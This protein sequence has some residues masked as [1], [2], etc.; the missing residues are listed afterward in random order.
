M[1]TYL[2][3][4]GLGR[5]QAICSVCLLMWNL[6]SVRSG[7]VVLVVYEAGP[8]V[9]NVFLR[10]PAFFLFLCFCLIMMSVSPV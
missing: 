7:A 6:F 1:T 2:L 8:W 5:I 4:L 9:C 10:F 3:F